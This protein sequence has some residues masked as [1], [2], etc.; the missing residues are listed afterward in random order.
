M[1]LIQLT[2]LSGAG[3][4]T[5][6][7]EAKR[8]LTD[9][10]YRVELLDGDEYRQN[11]CRDLGFSKA[12]RLENIRRLGFVG[13]AFAR[14]GVIAI[15]A[16]INPYEEGRRALQDGDACVRT[17]FINCPQDTLELRDVKGLYARA[18]LPEGHPERI[19]HFTGIS[20]PYEAPECADLIL[21]T[22]RE[23]P[24][25]SAARLV[26]FILRELPGSTAV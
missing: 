26:A 18:R 6:S 23:S 1:L 15:L 22:D 25:E 14:Q 10:G 11:L 8:Q 17:V 7:R 16:A 2:G 21:Q 24:A 13:Q 12:D 9:L 4:T 3:K 19:G 20:D 5:I